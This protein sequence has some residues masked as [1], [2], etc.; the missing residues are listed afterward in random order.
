[1]ILDVGCGCAAY[2]P[3]VT[4]RGD[5]NIDVSKPKGKVANFVLCDAHALPFKT[6]FFSTVFFYDVI[7]HVANPLRCLTE[8]CRCLR[9]KGSVYLST[10]NPLHWRKFLRALRGKDILLTPCGQEAVDYDHITTW[11]DAEMRH[12]LFRAGF[13]GV[14]FNFAILDATVLNNPLRS[15]IDIL[16]FKFGFKRVTGINMLVTAC[17]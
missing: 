7:E 16:M 1:M 3:L 4:A 9:R 14:S 10:P 13:K 17:K 12:I 8:I 2:G 6:G 5:V 15:R 11:T